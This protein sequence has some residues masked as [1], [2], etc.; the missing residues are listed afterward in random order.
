M[1]SEDA[2]LHTIFDRP[3]DPYPLLVYAD[4]LEEHGDPRHEVIRIR[5]ALEDN[6]TDRDLELAHRG[7]ELVHKVGDPMNGVAR[8]GRQLL[9]CHLVHSGF[10]RRTLQLSGALNATIDFSTLA[11]SMT[12]RVNGGVAASGVKA[13]S[14]PHAHL[15]FFIPHETGDVR[16]GLLADFGPLK[17][18]LGLVLSLGD[19]GAFYREGRFVSLEDNVYQPMKE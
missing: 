10:F 13:P 8:L 3:N 18:L 4:W 11:Y 7:Q 15:Q 6:P 2:L 17:G 14:E 19:K 9:K 5:T 1:T 16:F 12:V